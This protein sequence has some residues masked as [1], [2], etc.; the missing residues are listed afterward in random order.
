M[1]TGLDRQLMM[2]PLAICGIFWGQD[3]QCCPSSGGFAKGLPSLN[4]GTG[5]LTCSIVPIDMQWVK[6]STPISSLHHLAQ[7]FHP[8]HYVVVLHFNLLDFLL[9]SLD[10][11]FWYLTYSWRMVNYCTLLSSPDISLSTSGLFSLYACI[12]HTVEGRVFHGSVICL[13]TALELQG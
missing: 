11:L 12:S 3:A 4:F 9:M 7:I 10:I 5:A 8:V 1:I 6:S 2:G 13:K